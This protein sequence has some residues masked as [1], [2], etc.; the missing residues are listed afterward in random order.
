MLPSLPSD[1][2]PEDK[3]KKG[4]KW[5]HYSLAG[6]LGVSS[7]SLPAYNFFYTRKEAYIELSTLKERAKED[8]E[9]YRR[10]SKELLDWTKGVDDRLAKIQ[11]DVAV[12]KATVGIA[13]K[14][15]KKLDKMQKE[16]TLLEP[17]KHDGG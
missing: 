12:M 7:I 3:P 15:A 2:E 1:A 16:V 17:K 10:N 4:W 8:R 11:E 5:H 13:L 9:E 6:L 14:Q